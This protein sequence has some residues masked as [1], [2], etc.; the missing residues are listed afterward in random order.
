MSRRPLSD[1]LSWSLLPAAAIVMPVHAA[2]YLSVTQAQKLMF[3]QADSFVA[4][5]D[6]TLGKWQEALA[7]RLD[8]DVRVRRLKFW[9][10]GYVATDAVIGKFE[11]FD[12][13][14]A[15]GPDAVIRQIEVLNYLENHGMEVHD[16]PEWR[17]Q[18]TGKNADAAF[19]LESDIRTISGAT[20]S[21]SHL[22]DGIR[23]LTRLLKTGLGGSFK[24]P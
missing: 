23:T 16:D 15:F 11:L 14:V 7:K 22:S 20:L 6:A 10:L 12:F 24:S 5:A 19:S 9:L 2:T 1:L 17:K 4:V 13:A 21:C 8:D 18:F 3:P